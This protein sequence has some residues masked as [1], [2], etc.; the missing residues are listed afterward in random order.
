MEKPADR[1]FAADPG[2][3]A[4]PSAT[5]RAIAPGDEPLRGL[6]AWFGRPVFLEVR[7][8]FE[9]R[10]LRRSALWRGHG[11]PRGNG[12]PVLIIP[13]FMAASTSA[14]S[15]AHVLRSAGWNAEIAG[16][17]RN[18]GP[19]YAGLEQSSADLFDLIERHGQPVRVIGHSRGG[20][21]AR[22]LAVRHPELVAGV[23]AVG[24]PLLSKYPLFA[25]V[26][27]PIEMLEITWRRGTFGPVDPDLEAVV[28]HDRF[29]PFPEEIEFVSIYSRNDGI[30]DWRACLDP[31]ATLVQVSASHTG[32]INSV[33]G[34]R[35]I[36]VALDE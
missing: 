30:V 10:A 18:S 35:A 34:V 15:L 3:G 17:G 27:I 29:R 13:G 7:S 2:V 36:A 5:G 31:A 9:L 12:R 32:L 20:Q 22:I 16:V 1:T 28:D 11:V 24:A 14:D 8:P 4:P 26:R 33:A 23:V 19:A 6:A 25:P 21:F